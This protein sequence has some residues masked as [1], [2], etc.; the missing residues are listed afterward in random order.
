MK[1][2]NSQACP[3]LYHPPPTSLQIRT[4][5][6]AE[7]YKIQIIARNCL[8]SCWPEEIIILPVAL[9]NTFWSLISIFHQIFLYN[10]VPRLSLFKSFIGFFF[11]PFLFPYNNATERIGQ[12]IVK[13]DSL[14]IILALTFVNTVV[15]F[16]SF[17]SDAFTHS[18]VARSKRM[19]SVWLTT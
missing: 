16:M 4:N 1:I 2:E 3:H 19:R 7:N 8:S 18:S 9:S 11:L 13:D 6:C 14:L 10:L 12:W 17:A 5:L 15:H